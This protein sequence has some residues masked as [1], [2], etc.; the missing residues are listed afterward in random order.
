MQA[1]KVF[2]L[3]GLA[4]LLALFVL[5]AI[6]LYDE[7]LS[8]VSEQALHYQVPS[9]PPEENAFIAQMGFSAPA[10][11][12]FI[13]VG[14]ERVRLLA[15]G[16]APPPDEA[17]LWFHGAPSD[18]CYCTN[19]NAPKCLEG[20]R[21]IR[22]KAENIRQGIEEN[23]EM[24]ERYL[25]IMSLPVYAN[26]F[27]NDTLSAPGDIFF[28][29]PENDRL[30]S[31][32]QF[33]TARA[34]LDIQE[35]RIAEGLAWMAKNQ[36]LFRKIYAAKEATFVDKL[37][38]IRQI[39]MQT[40]LLGHLIA[41]NAL[42]DQAENARALLTPLENPK[43]HYLEARWREHVETLNDQFYYG[44]AN[45]LESDLFDRDRDEE[46]G[47]GQKLRA[48]FMYY[49]LHKKNMSTNLKSEFLNH[50]IAL[51]HETPLPRLAA[52]RKIL[53][54][55]IRERVCGKAPE[56][57]FAC[58]HPW[59]NYVGEFDHRRYPTLW[60]NHYL[61]EILDV[62]A[63]IRLTRAQLEYQLAVK[64]HQGAPADVPQVL[65]TLGPE[66]FNPYTEQPFEWNP[67][68]GSIGFLPAA[69]DDG[70]ARLWK[71]KERVEARLRP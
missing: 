60:I 55:K 18:L 57:S 67:E 31:A 28:Y 59:R 66:T 2:A 71:D 68:K 7:P 9:V 47:Y 1:K 44:L 26:V 25:K 70:S 3:A 23:R 21:A 14:E 12:D 22:E 50:E 48:Y 46:I 29:V 13:R 32:S 6:F 40:M 53:R 24:T 36:T 54:E 15:Q 63:T 38:A 61:F 58:K 34:L 20:I 41:Q 19:L 4:A 45:L 64:N 42:R 37:T 33:L 11:S 69:P 43:E 8:P 27:V 17:S 52:E 10:G 16:I 65:A 56:D 30:S 62:D 5:A 51:I 39:Q 35:G 49:F